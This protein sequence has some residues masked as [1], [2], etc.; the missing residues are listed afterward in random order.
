[1]TDLLTVQDFARKIGKSDRALYADIARGRWP[2]VKIGRRVFFKPETLDRF[3]TAHERPALEP[4]NP[5]EKEA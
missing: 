2:T 1:M 5:N 4:P 3:I